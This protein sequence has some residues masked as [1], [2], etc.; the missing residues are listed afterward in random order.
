[1]HHKK[2]DLCIIPVAKYSA[3]QGLIDKPESKSQVQAQ[4]GK[5]EFGLW[6]VTKILWATTNPTTPPKTFK[7]EGGL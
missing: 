3:N 4:R 1:M 2:I 5:K 7:H 6:A